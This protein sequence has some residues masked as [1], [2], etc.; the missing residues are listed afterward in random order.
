MS[1]SPAFTP[2]ASAPGPRAGSS[3]LRI[4]LFLSLVAA[5]LVADL[6]I[7]YW[8]FAKVAGAPVEIDVA[9]P[10]NTY[11][12]PHDPIHVVPGVL[13]L[14]LTTN[15]GAVFGLGKG[16]RWFFVAV[17]AVATAVILRVFWR[18]P[19]P[20]WPLQ[21]ALALVLGGALGNLYDRVRYAAVRDMFWLLEGW[22]LPF[23][24]RWPGGSRD[25][26][27][28]LFNL[29]DAAL[30]GGVILLLLIMWRDERRAPAT[31]PTPG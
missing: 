30:V 25:V 15:T 16:A 14:H 27:P 12:P 19:L 18:S 7:K 20:A 3:P 21:V 11:I 26:Y 13:S 2:P 5:V 28:W 24:L 10:R 1:S 6:A 4:A 23:N 8:S 17:T 9:D 31:P 29:A 22:E